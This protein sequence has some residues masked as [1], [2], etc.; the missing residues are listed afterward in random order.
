LTNPDLFKAKLQELR[1]KSGDLE[2]GE[3]TF[4]SYLNG[5]IQ[6]LDEFKD[7]MLKKQSSNELKEDIAS[8][9]KFK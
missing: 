9:R 3:G 8:F 7:G 6:S 1:S 5:R 4:R 2:Y